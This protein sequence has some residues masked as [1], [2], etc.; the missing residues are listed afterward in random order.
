MNKVTLWT[1]VLHNKLLDGA[2]PPNINHKIAKNPYLSRHPH[3]PDAVLNEYGEQEWEAKINE[4][5]TCKNYVC[6]V[7]LIEHMFRETKK[8]LSTPCT[9]TTGSFTMTR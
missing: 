6:I 3:H 1:G 4:S 9:K 2:C 8:Y 5:P 7:R